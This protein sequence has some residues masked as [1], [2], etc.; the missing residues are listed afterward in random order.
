MPERASGDLGEILFQR[1]RQDV[2]TLG[3]LLDLAH[4]QSVDL[5]AA[6]G[7]LG[8]VGFEGALEDV[9]AF[10]QLLD[11][12]GDEIVDA[13]AAFRQ[14]CEIVP[15]GASAWRGLPRSGSA[16]RPRG[17]RSARG[18]CSTRR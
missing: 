16:G 5:R 6:L 2:A 15:S 7:E 3:D 10:G 4:D 17:T 11:L 8:K 18:R 9:A 1:L 14:L 13:R 12:G